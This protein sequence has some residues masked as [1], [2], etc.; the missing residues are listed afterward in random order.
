MDSNIRVNDLDF[1]PMISAKEIAGRVEALGAQ[2]TQDY[3]D[4]PPHFIAVLNGAFIFAADLIRAVQLDST[5]GFVKLSSYSGLN[6][7]GEVKTDLS[8]SPEQVKGQHLIIVEDIVDTGKTLSSFTNDLKAWEPASIKIAA[9]LL[10][11]EALQHPIEVD[12]LGFSIPPA[13]VIG[14][15][16]DYDE[17]GRQLDAIYQKV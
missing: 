1:R 6:S 16:L 3:P 4:Q 7:T 12:Y 8:L 2:I 17:A 5:V 14:Y 15:G 10:K 9:L 13:F 11:P